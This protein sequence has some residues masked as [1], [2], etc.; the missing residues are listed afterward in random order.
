VV[1]A[2]ARR[3][4]VDAGHHDLVLADPPYRFDGWVDLLRALSADLV[5]IESD[6]LVDVPSGWEVV[7]D[8]RYGSTVVRVARCLPTDDRG[9][10]P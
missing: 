1:R 8:R 6:R 7:R 4:V 3:W 2:D 10:L 9:G 5:V